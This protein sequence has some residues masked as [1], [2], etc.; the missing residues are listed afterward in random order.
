MSDE[1]RKSIIA[2]LALAQGVSESV[3]ANYTNEQLLEEMN[4]MFGKKDK[5]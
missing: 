5:H 4:R 2:Q 1:E 3:F